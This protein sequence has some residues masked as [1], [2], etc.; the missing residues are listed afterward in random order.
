MSVALNQDYNELPTFTLST[1][2]YITK[3]VSKSDP[4]PETSNSIQTQPATTPNPT[5]AVAP[6]EVGKQQETSSSKRCFFFIC[7]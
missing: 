3:V 5:P 2:G 7:L 4:T 1:S 6:K